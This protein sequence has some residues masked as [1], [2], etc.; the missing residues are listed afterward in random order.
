MKSTPWSTD[1][2][3]RLVEFSGTH[4]RDL[5]GGFCER[6]QAVLVRALDAD[7]RAVHAIAAIMDAVAEC[8]R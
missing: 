7:P 5:G 3:A 6:V 1:F 8:E 4:S 2:G